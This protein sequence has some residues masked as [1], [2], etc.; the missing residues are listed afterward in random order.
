MG[1]KKKTNATKERVGDG[2][3]VREGKAGM[4]QEFKRPRDNGLKGRGAVN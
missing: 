4:I 1:G 2:E 3:A